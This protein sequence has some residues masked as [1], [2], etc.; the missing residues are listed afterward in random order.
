MEKLSFF[1]KNR[2]VSIFVY[3]MLIGIIGTMISVELSDRGQS[4]LMQ[5]DK[6]K[7]EQVLESAQKGVFPEKSPRT[8]TSDI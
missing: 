7:R 5:N 4:A 8:L 6:Q 3:L 2:R 1:M